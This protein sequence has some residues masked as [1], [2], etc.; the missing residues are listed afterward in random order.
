MVFNWLALLRGLKVFKKSGIKWLVFDLGGVVLEAKAEWFL[1]ALPE[2]DRKSARIKSHDLMSLFRGYEANAGK[3][4]EAAL[5][6]EMRAIL[7]SQI[8]DQALISAIDAMLGQPIPEMYELIEQSTHRFQI[9]CLSNTNYI[10]WPK[11]LERYPVI[12]FFNPALASHELGLAKPNLAV[13][14]KVETILNATPE[15]I[16]FFDD[17]QENVSAALDAGWRAF[18]FVTPEDCRAQIAQIW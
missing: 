6:N 16:A 10:H 13:Y 9:A 1:D 2:A 3:S 14:H 11:I 18:L 15:Q 4:N 8:S 17:K 12:K 7:S 5:F